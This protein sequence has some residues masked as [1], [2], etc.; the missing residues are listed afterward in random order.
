MLN[1]VVPEDLSDSSMRS[2]GLDALESAASTRN[3]NCK[4]VEET[5]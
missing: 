1:D 4:L 3:K 5:S 2:N